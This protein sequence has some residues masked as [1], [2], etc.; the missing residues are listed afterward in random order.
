MEGVRV[1][2][3]HAEMRLLKQAVED[4]VVLTECTTMRLGV[5]HRMMPVLIRLS[6]FPNLLAYSVY[7][8][9]LPFGNLD[10]MVCSCM[11]LFIFACVYCK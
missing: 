5:N 6:K 10:I 9:V 11:Y 1:K 8:L 7:C 4:H 3:G 2:K